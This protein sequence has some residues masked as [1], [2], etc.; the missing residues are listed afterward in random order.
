M[1]DKLIFLQLDF[2][3][4]NKIFK[5]VLFRVGRTARAGRAGVAITF[6]SQY[7]IELYQRIEQLLGQSIFFYRH[8]QDAALFWIKSKVVFLTIKS[9]RIFF[10]VIQFYFN[11]QS[12]DRL[13]QL[14]IRI[15]DFFLFSVLFRIFNKNILIFNLQQKVLIYEISLKPE[16]KHN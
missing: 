3:I 6:V 12:H 8:F 9:M 5:P 7:D 2:A 11:S 16:Y 1:Q 13:E 15:I 10:H 14:P 4:C